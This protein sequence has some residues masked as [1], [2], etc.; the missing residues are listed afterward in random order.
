[1]QLVIHPGGVVRCAYDEAIDLRALG[2]LSVAR[3]SHVEPDAD[4][5]WLA[6]LGPVGGPLLGPFPR[7]SAAL[8]AEVDWLGRHWLESSR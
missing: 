2:R 4:G 7:R 1:M 3:A 8:A 5:Q 6:D